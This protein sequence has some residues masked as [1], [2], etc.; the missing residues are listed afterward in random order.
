MFE[1]V[2]EV[3]GK[4]EYLGL[5]WEF[6][7]PTVL[8][9]LAFFALIVHALTRNI[10]KKEAGKKKFDQKIL[11]VMQDDLVPYSDYASSYASEIKRRKWLKSILTYVAIPC[12]LGL[13]LVRQDDKQDTLHGAVV[14][15]IA[16]TREVPRKNTT[17]TLFLPSR[18]R[19]ATIFLNGKPAVIQKREPAT[20]EII[21]P[22][23]TSSNLFEIVVS[24]ESQRCKTWIKITKPNQ[25]IWPCD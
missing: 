16:G 9:V 15:T 21:V 1:T 5:F 13:A 17:A 24:H 12:A 22:A 19:P 3:F 23:R 10:K 8:S 6:I 20:L 14:Y 25:F 11:Q 4:H 2:V 18:L 7:T